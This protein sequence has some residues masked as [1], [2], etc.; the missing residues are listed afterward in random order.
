MYGSGGWNRTIADE[1]MSLANY[2][3]ST[4]LFYKSFTTE[5]VS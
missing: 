4:P 3:C 1:I 5:H 2:H